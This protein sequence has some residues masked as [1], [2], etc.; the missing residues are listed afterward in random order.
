MTADVSSTER[1]PRVL[2]VAE[3]ANPEWTSVPLV[4]WSHCEAL[5]EVA[6]AHV[7]TQVRNREAI[8]RAGWR[9]GE[10]FT[11]IDSETVARV[12][13]W[14]DTAVRKRT[15][16]GWTFTT[17]LGSAA[18]PEFERKL[19]KRFG[20][21][22]RAGAYDLV[23][24][25]TPL[26]PTT[27]S[28]VLAPRL[29]QAGVPFVWGPING[30]VAWPPGFGDVQRA[31]G[32]W[33]AYVRGAHRFLPGFRATRRSAAAIIAGSEATWAQLEGHHARC[34][35]VPENA[36][37]PARFTER[38]E[39]FGAE[40]LRVAFVGRLV[41]YKGA[42]MLIEAAAPL[43]KAG[44]L[45]L[46]IIGDGPEMERL[47]AMRGP[48]LEAGI[49]LPGF[50]PHAELQARLARAHVLGFPSVREFGG[51][52]A[53]EAMALGVVPVVVGYAGPNEL[54]SDA[55]GVRV[56]VG[57]RAS[58]VQGFRRAFE[59]LLDAPERLASMAEAGRHRVEEHFTWR[60]KARQTLEVYRWVLGR[61]DKPDFGMPFPDAERSASA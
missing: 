50:I 52:V 33:L 17:A 41:P 43:V 27:P 8:E 39:P 11:A 59:E 47:K 5:R 12:L 54:V 23:H 16:L 2:L 35:Y 22:I 10:E 28:T 25:V 13:Y 19:W 26:S 37:D 4:G 61:R 32:E 36:V 58:I 18:Y 24:R 40:P 44:R 57:P 30:G 31:E 42:D 46:D 21:A 49:E 34:V 53:L 29:A 45:T 56:P 14:L 1:P 20:P 55:T 7:V 3:A 6:D 60:A 38:A 9:E 48:D 15:G 51:A